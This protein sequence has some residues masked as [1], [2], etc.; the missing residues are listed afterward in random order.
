MFLAVE[1]VS[2]GNQKIYKKV[3]SY[4]PQNEGKLNLRLFYSIIIKN[5]L[6]VKKLFYL[7][8]PFFNLT[9]VLATKELK[10][11]TLRKF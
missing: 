10:K 8:L 6:K 1:I 11:K 3:I 5:L 4:K 2:S 9:S 7:L